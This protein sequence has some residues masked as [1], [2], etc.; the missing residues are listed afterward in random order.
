MTI[1]CMVILTHD[2]ILYCRCRLTCVTS[3]Y[4]G[5]QA[6]GSSSLKVLTPT[7]DGGPHINNRIVQPLSQLTYAH[8]SETFLPKRLREGIF[9]STSTTAS[10]IRTDAHVEEG[11]LEP[12]PYL[13]TLR[14]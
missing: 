10:A 13:T 1:P 8:K 11:P 4:S 9:T 14:P 3:Q 6:D 5:L 12:K 7:T 2:Y